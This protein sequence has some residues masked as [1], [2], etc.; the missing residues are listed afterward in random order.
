M[1]ELSTNSEINAAGANQLRWI[2]RGSCFG[3]ST[4]STTYNCGFVIILPLY[5]VCATFGVNWN[6]AKVPLQATVS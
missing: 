6:T 4:A 2:E 1:S 3:A 5:A